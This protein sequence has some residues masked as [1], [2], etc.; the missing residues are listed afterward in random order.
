MIRKTEHCVKLLAVFVPLSCP[1]A[2]T[3]RYSLGFLSYRKDLT[4]GSTTPDESFSFRWAGAGR[5][6]GSLHIPAHIITGPRKG[7][8]YSPGRQTTHQEQLSAL[9]L[10][11]A[12][13]SLYSRTSVRTR[14]VDFKGKDLAAWSP[15]SSLMGTINVRFYILKNFKKKIVY[16]DSCQ[17][18]PSE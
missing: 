10:P 16:C 18:V 15:Q 1:F 4:L 9:V 6:L 7:L 17:T 2:L 5:I 13:L 3:F 12:A 11:D 14:E 8:C